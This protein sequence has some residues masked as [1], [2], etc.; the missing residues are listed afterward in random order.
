LIDTNIKRVNVGSGDTEIPGFIGLDAKRGD[1][2]YPLYAEGL[3]EIRASHCLEHFSGAEIPLVIADWVRAL[4]PGGTLKIAVPDF[5]ILAEQFVAGTELPYQSFIM[6][7]QTDALDYH[8]A[9]FDESTLANLMRDNGLVS[10]RRWKSEIE[11]CAAL[12]IS[13]NLAGTK[14]MP[15]PKV[16]AVISC[17]RLGFNDFWACA[18]AHLSSM[19]ISLRKSGGAY[20]ERDLAVGIELALKE[21]DPEFIL[22]CDYDSIFT[23][24]H[25]QDLIDIARRYPHAHAIA[26]VQPARHH[27]RPIFTALDA[28]GRLIQ[29]VSREDLI[30]G[31]ILKARTAHFGLTLFRADKLRDLPKPWMIRKLDAEGT[32]HGPE[33]MD[34]DVQFWE[35][36]GNAGN[37][38][39]I[40]LR[41]PIG[42]AELMVR[43]PD[44]DFG[45]IHQKPG[46]FFKDGPPFRVW[47]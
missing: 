45:T 24:R 2:I 1:S 27:D 12:P 39:Y 8:K 43:W 36:W 16:S 38:L 32:Y 21:E 30:H 10:I 6:G 35:S 5:R 26:P 44:S 11:D 3:S 25:V 23:A 41:V 15:I 46:E 29:K 18:Y 33:A 9:L 22:T 19:G 42:H 37:N 34:P 28:E 20:W 4:A 40:A 31:E 14:P 47:R 7:G 17:P 13:L